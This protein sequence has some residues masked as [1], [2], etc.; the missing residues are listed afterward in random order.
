MRGLTIHWVWL[1]RHRVQR[2][3]GCREQRVDMVMFARETNLNGYW[4]TKFGGSRWSWMSS[5]GIV[6]LILECLE[7]PEIW[8]LAQWNNKTRGYDFSLQ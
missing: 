2:F 8:H 7:T 3:R 1:D 4:L 5:V 6:T